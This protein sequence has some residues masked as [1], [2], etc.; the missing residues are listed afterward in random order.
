MPGVFDVEDAG[1]WVAP[2]VH[3][4][5]LSCQAPKW[6]AELPLAYEAWSG[7]DFRK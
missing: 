3:D 6:A 2:R 1:Y 7:A 5:L 4:E